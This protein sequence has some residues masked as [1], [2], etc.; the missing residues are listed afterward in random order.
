MC[1]VSNPCA[2]GQCSSVGRGLRMPTK[3]EVSNPCASGQ[4]SSGLG[5]QWSSL[6]DWL[7]Q[8]P[9]PRGGVPLKQEKRGE[10]G[11]PSRFK[12]LRLGAV[13]L[14]AITVI[15]TQTN[16]GFKPLRLGAVF[17]CITRRRCT[18]ARRKFQTPAPRGGVPL[19]CL[20]SPS[21]EFYSC[22]KPLRLGAVFLC[23]IGGR[24]DVPDR[25]S[26]KPL[27]LGAVFLCP[28]EGENIVL[29]GHVSNPCASGRCSSV[30]RTRTEPMNSPR[31]KPL[32]LGA[33]FLWSSARQQQRRLTSFKPLRLGAVFLCTRPSA[34]QNRGDPRFKPL[35]LGAVFLCGDTH[36]HGITGHSVS[37]PCASGR[38]S[39]VVTIKYVI[40]ITRR[41]KPLR[42]GA[43]F[44]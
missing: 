34:V 36:I 28:G 42:L 43:V 15:P 21:P 7:F 38:C 27:R 5:W 10:G 25:L 40:L 44:L 20:Y 1:N 18:M 13:F 29:W 14:W 39:S 30:T 23:Y 4:C 33:V 3:A 9:A 35:R 24:I 22:F 37:N 2:S 17:L 8:T 26:F 41:F 11:G 16:G 31:F 12:P 19:S 32:R 6:L